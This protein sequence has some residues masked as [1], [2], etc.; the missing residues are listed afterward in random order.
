MKIL[1]TIEYNG[2]D[3]A[4]WQTQNKKRTVQTEL[5]NSLFLIFREKIKVYGSG[6]TDSGVH[7]FAQTAHFELSSSSVSKFMILGKLNLN[8]LIQA[9]NSNIPKDIQV[10]KAKKVSTG[11]H[12]RFDVKEKVYI[13]KMQEN[14]YRPSPLNLNFVGTCRDVLDV[15]KMKEAAQYL[16][17]EHDFTSFSN[18]KTTVKDFTRRINYIKIK[19]Q[20]DDIVCFEIS[21]NGFL[22]NMVRIIV[23]TLVDV[24][25]SRIKPIDVKTILQN[26]NRTSAG[27]TVSSSGLYLKKVRY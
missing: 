2:T 20:K 7:A 26:K 13:Y 16:I 19:K 5:E 23:G 3:F 8:K 18:S 10:L 27:K 1:L 4:G 21:G 25:I 9:I 11:F 12:A 24:G 17:G 15:D 14:T 6:R 22:Y